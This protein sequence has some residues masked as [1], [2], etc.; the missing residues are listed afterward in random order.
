M[1]VVFLFDTSLGREAFL[2]NTTGEGSV[3]G[4][5]VSGLVERGKNRAKATKS[6]VQDKG[7][8]KSVGE[9]MD[10]FDVGFCWT[11]P[12]C[13]AIAH[14]ASDLCF[15]STAATNLDRHH[16]LD[17]TRIHSKLYIVLVRRSL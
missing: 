3:V 8:E 15:S 16:P 4:G 5:I 12:Q 1:A 10:G 14:T 6:G 2:K 9:D 13:L 11:Q 7:K 17:S